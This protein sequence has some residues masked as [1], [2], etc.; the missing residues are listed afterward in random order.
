[1]PASGIRASESAILQTDSFS[2]FQAYGV[3]VYVLVIDRLIH[4]LG[5]YSKR[6]DQQPLF[7]ALLKIKKELGFILLQ[8]AVFQNTISKICVRELD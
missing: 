7:E 4:T 2:P 8:L 3:T 5:K 6:N 1:M